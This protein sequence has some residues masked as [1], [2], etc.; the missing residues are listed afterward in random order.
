MC[1]SIINPL[2]NRLFYIDWLRIFAVLV[3]FPFHTGEIFNLGPFYVKNETDSTVILGINLFINIWHMHLFMFL[4]GASSCL[5]LN[6]RS[7]KQYVWER[8]KRIFIPLLFGLLI[9]VPP[10]SYLRMFGNPDRTWRG[11]N[12]YPGFQGGLGYNKSF[13][14]FYPDFFNGIYPN[15]NFEWAHL[16]FLAYLFVFSM[17]ALPLFSYLKKEQG[18]KLLK[19]IADR[20]IRPYRIF[21]LIIPITIFEVLLRHLYPDGNQNLVADWANFLT[22]FTI[23]FYGYILF[24]DKR[25][26]DVIEKYKA[27]AFKLALILSAFFMVYTFKFDPGDTINAKVVVTYISMMI[28]K[29]A[30]IICWL[31]AFLGYGKAYI[32][33]ESRLR[34]YA[35]EAVLPW[36][37]LHQTIILIIGFYII[38]FDRVISISNT[39]FSKY[40]ITLFASFIAVVLIYDFFIRRIRFMRLMFGLKLA[41]R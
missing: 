4:A 25:L 13:L 9:I 41:R 27:F 12:P 39:I 15:G 19:K 20:L 24:S 28:V 32:N 30:A 1:K 37:I 2:D 17:I 5:A 33:K 35:A 14:E 21:L 38:Q 36:Y 6:I 29:S 8:C 18:T 23:F 3:L 26:I 31:I 16:W 10:Q 7:I 34:R 11:G 40:F 22:Y